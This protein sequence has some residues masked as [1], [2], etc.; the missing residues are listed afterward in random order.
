MPET[1]PVIII[2]AAGKG[3]RF[4]A[5]GGTTHKL[6]ALLA[7]K[8]VLQH[9]LAAAQASGLPWHLVRP[10]GGTRG[11]G[12][13]IALGVK[14]TPD[15]AGWLILLGD[16]PLITAA[17]LQRVAQ[18]LN[19]KPVVVPYYQQRHGHPVGF[20]REY[21]DSLARL[22]GDEG[23]KAVVQAARARADVLTLTLNDPG[24]V[25]DID[26]PED[27]AAAEHDKNNAIQILRTRW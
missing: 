19:E 7:G 8:P 6:E 20:R 4:R 21:F 13:S 24:I 23:A 2:L 1:Q 5:G 10:E 27:L 26:V 15:A 25:Q 3:A 17:S 14:A 16:L 11:M 18:A 12:E 22:T 9:V